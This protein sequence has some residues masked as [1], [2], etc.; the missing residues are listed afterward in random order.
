M[1]L[2]RTLPPNTKSGLED[3]RRIKPYRQHYQPIVERSKRQTDRKRFSSSNRTL[4]VNRLALVLQLSLIKVNGA[5]LQYHNPAHRQEGRH[6]VFD[7]I[8]K[9]SR[10]NSDKCFMTTNFGRTSGLMTTMMRLVW[11]LRKA[12]PSEFGP[13]KPTYGTSTR[14]SKVFVFLFCLGM[15]WHFGSVA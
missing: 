11:V 6:F 4:F 7:L 1:L 13:A 3:W 14:P 10:P 9:H 2:I 15:D 8:K 12:S 5:E